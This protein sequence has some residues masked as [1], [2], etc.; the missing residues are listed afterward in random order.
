LLKKEYTVIIVKVSKMYFVI[1][2][3]KNL[4]KNYILKKT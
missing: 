4:H 3:I 1:E 2:Y